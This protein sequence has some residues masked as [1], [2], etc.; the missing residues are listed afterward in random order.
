MTKKGASLNNAS[1]AGGVDTLQS[2]LRGL[3]KT[4]VTAANRMLPQVGTQMAA[5]SVEQES[6][7]AADILGQGKIRR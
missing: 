1:I 5:N 6:K 4:P 7:R 3:S 2:R